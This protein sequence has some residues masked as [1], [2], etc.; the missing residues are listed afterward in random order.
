MGQ[1]EERERA[2][3][4]EA[5]VRGHRAGRAGLLLDD[6]AMEG[7]TASIIAQVD[8]THPRQATQ[9]RAAIEAA[10]YERAAMICAEESTSP[11]ASHVAAVTAARC[12]TRIRA[13][14]TEQPTAPVVA[15]ARVCER[16]GTV[17]EEGPGRYRGA[18]CIMPESA[19]VNAKNCGGKIVE[20]IA[21]RVGM[22][23]EGLW[24]DPSSIEHGLKRIRQEATAPVVAAVVAAIIADLRARAAGHLAASKREGTSAAGHRYTHAALQD[25]ADRIAAAHPD[26]EP[27]LDAALRALDAKDGAR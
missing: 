4:R 11:G 20:Q 16:C 26:A 25:A 2:L 3:V 5:L 21:A 19:A 10:A 17:Y 27:R 8:R 23:P 14:S 15:N 13:L 6:S 22:E 1:Q 24:E 7:P 9:G 18:K 12:E